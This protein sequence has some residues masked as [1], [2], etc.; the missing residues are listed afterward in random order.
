MELEP[1]SAERQQQPIQGFGNLPSRK[2]YKA[3]D[4]G[5]TYIYIC[6]Q[7]LN[8]VFNKVH[9]IVRDEKGEEVCRFTRG[10]SGLYIARMKLK[11]PF[12]GPG[13]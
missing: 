5:G 8:V 2:S 13:S 12:G 1:G 9:A 3:I 10:E 4:V 11:T 7:G 6:D